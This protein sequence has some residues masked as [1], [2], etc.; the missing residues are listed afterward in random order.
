LQE[1]PQNKLVLGGD[2]RI[3]S[4]LELSVLHVIL[5]HPHK[6]SIYIGFAVRAT[7]CQNLFLLLVFIKILFKII[8]DVVQLGFSFSF[9][10]LKAI[11]LI[12]Y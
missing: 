6:S 1:E 9:P 12:D 11:Y 4:G 8:P 10:S 2:L 7:L 3:V 5:L